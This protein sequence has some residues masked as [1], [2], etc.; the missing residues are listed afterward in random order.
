MDH[1]QRPLLTA[2][3]GEACDSMTPHRG[4]L[5]TPG[6]NITRPSRGPG[7]TGRRSEDD[8]AAGQAVEGSFRR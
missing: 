1:E 7:R 8:P 3:R 4:W 5:W 6:A 2:T